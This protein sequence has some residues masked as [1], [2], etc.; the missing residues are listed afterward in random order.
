MARI[1][2]HGKSHPRLLEAARSIYGDE[3]QKITDRLSV[4]VK[5]SS[6]EDLNQRR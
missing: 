2:A 6:D 5:A 4:K 1:V 3:W